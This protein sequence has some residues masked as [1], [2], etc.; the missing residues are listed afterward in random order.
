MVSARV[1]SRSARTLL[2]N[3]H[4]KLILRPSADQMSPNQ[5]LTS[6]MSLFSLIIFVIND[7]CQNLI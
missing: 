6:L 7:P 4:V 3:T 2:L 5:P 1:P